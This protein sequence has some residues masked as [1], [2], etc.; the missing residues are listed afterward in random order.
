ME[1]KHEPIPPLTQAESN[2]MWETVISQIRLK[3]KRKRKNKVIKLTS[4]IA[5]A[6]IL[7]L[8]GIFMYENYAKSDVYYANNGE[9][10]VILKDSTHVT[11]QP[12][13][14][15]TVERNFPS[16]TR[17]VYLNGDAIFRVSKS[18]DHPF[19][20]HTLAYDTKVLGT[21]FKITQRGQ[22]FN[23]DL[24]EGKVQVIKTEKP[25]EAFVIHPKE[26][27]SNFGYKDVAT[28][29]NTKSTGGS[30]NVNAATISFTD[31]ELFNAIKILENTY[32]IEVHFPPSVANSK[33]SATKEKATAEDLIRLISLKLNLKTTKINDKTFQL[34]E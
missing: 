12:G 6:V 33:I 13:A 14:K 3:E 34:E 10:I 7:I 28:I 30:Q 8:G 2:E 32:G 16:K 27:F 1:D 9:K 26:T 25:T 23:V 29:V 5:I 11:L 17:D 24:Y 20:V 21:V 15:L 19:I 18:K 4:S 22:D 31:L